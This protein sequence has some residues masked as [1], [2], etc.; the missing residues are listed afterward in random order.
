ML[1]VSSERASR[2]ML[3]RAKPNLIALYSP[4]AGEHLM[5]IANKFY[6]NPLN[7]KRIATRNSLGS[8]LILTG[9]ELLIIPEAV[10]RS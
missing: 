5:K 6:A 1:V 7:W 8:S 10:A 2:E 4:K 9:E 3:S